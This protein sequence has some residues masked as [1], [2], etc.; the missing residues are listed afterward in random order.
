M[1][2]TRKSQD[3]RFTSSQNLNV[4]LLDRAALRQFHEHDDS[5]RNIPGLAAASAVQDQVPY[6]LSPVVQS[7]QPS[8]V[9]PFVLEPLRVTKI[10]RALL[11]HCALHSN[12][13]MFVF[14][15]SHHHQIIDLVFCLLVL[16]C[17][18]TVQTWL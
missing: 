10:S 1:R 3:R 16:R 17:P 9:L 18:L 13:S 4:V 14:I 2:F 5:G 8:P 15:S 12:L 6:A 7:L 11:D